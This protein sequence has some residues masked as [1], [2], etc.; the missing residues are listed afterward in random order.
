[1]VASLAFLRMLTAR[2]PPRVP[3]SR[4]LLQHRPSGVEAQIVKLTEAERSQVSKHLDMIG[5]ELQNKLVEGVDAYLQ[6]P[7]FYNDRGNINRVLTFCGVPKGERRDKLIWRYS[8]VGIFFASCAA[9]HWKSSR[10]MQHYY[11]NNLEKQEEIENLA[12]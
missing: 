11:D 10:C 1:M 6:R 4:R 2:R 12:T 8:L 3:R 9:G 7:T 5:E